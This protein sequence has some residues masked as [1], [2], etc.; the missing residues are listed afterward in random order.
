VDELINEPHRYYAV[1]ILMRAIKDGGKADLCM[2]VIHLVDACYQADALEKGQEVA[3]SL[4]SEFV[5]SAGNDVR[6]EPWMVGQP[7]EL[8]D[9]LAP[10]AEVYSRFV[11]VR[12]LGSWWKRHHQWNADD[13]EAQDAISPQ[14][15]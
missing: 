12:E 13:E 4:V 3:K 2:E 11:G 8:M 10:G 7:F 1:P 9:K 5:A 15:K 14:S 6:W